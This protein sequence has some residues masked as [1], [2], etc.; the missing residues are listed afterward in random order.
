MQRWWGGVV[1][2]YEGPNLRDYGAGGG[3]KHAMSFGAVREGR[4]HV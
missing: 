1:Q 3:C 4:L 2:E